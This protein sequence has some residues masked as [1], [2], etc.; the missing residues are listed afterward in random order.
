MTTKE[1]GLY[2]RA[3]RI[4][5][6]FTAEY[7]LW[8]LDVTDEAIIVKLGAH[9]YRVGYRLAGDDADP[10]FDLPAQWT[11]VEE[12]SEWVAKAARVAGDLLVVHGGQIKALG[13]GKLGGYLVTFTDPTRPDLEG[14]Y[15]DVKTE[16]ALV[17]PK[18]S[19]YYQHGLDPSIG[20]GSIGQGSLEKQDVGVWIDAQL[21]MRSEYE[22]A[23]YHLAEQGKLG[24][25]SGTAPNLVSREK[26]G[27]AYHITQWPLGVDASLTP[28]PA[29]PMN[30][31]V[32]LKLF[33]K[34]TQ[35]LEALLEGGGN[36][37]TDANGRNDL[38]PENELWM[39]KARLRNL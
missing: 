4:E 22:E 11:E 14:D 33:A 21:A 17:N 37:P 13:D 2:S 36:P 34:S 15:F 35:G 12:R 26:V 25:S 31:A 3:Y 23:I 1:E 7:D 9:Y 6:A 28:T 5:A 27:N 29:E 39:A 20:K 24:W 38:S 30:S 32:P 19:V 16:F 10:V 8:P 18:T